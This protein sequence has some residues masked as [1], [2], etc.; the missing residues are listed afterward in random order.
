MTQFEDASSYLD[1]TIG[2]HGIYIT[3]PDPRRKG[4]LLNA[5]YL[6]DV[7]PAQGWSKIEAVD[8]AIQKAGFHGTI[9]EDVRKTVRLRRYQSEA[10]DATWEHFVEWRT[11]KGGSM[12]CNEL[13]LK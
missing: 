13:A 3:F 6:P 10:A 12:K 4:K 11:Q 7:T 1:W 5:T 2:V 9:T 8:S